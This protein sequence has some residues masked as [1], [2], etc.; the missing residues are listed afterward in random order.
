MSEGWLYLQ[1]YTVMQQA[2]MLLSQ[3]KYIH[4]LTNRTAYSKQIS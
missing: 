3:T 4:E 2:V 1:S